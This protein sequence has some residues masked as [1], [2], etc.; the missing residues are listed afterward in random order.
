[1]N[2]IIGLSQ[3]A[4][5]RDTSPEVRDYLDKISS[6]SQSLLGILNDILDFSKLE[7]GRMSV[8]N[9]QFDLDQVLDNIRNLFEE[10][11]EAKQLEFS[12]D[13]AEGT[14]RDLVG[15][16][17]RIQQILSN[18]IGNA[19][20][21]TAQGRVVLNVSIRQ[22]DPAQVWMSFAVTDTGIGLSEEDKSKLFQPFSQVDG[23]I[24][25]KFGG[26]GLGLAISKNLLGLMGSQF[27]VESQPGKGSTFSFDVQLGIATTGKMR[28]V[29]VR[30]KHE[31]GQLARNLQN[32]ASSLKGARILVAEDNAINQQVVKEF[33]KLS[34]MEVEIARNGLEALTLLEQQE[35]DAVLMDVHMPVMGG[36]EATQKIRQNPKHAN[37]PV[38]AL[39]AGVTEEEREDTQAS[40]M[41]DFVAKPV[42]PEAL[43][44]T[45]TRWVN[46]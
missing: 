9:A 11:A 42:N 4:L 29:R 13:V 17:M 25:R 32:S 6:S 15:D 38:I 41:N 27:T 2:G 35:F 18:L 37:L 14:P 33:L 43:I 10:R 22:R 39:T 30:N 31:A 23:S 44:A 7:A 24:T 40:G 45:L 34:G 19:I 28:E 46:R 1:M 5:N 26:T 16:A 36:F 8:E 21:F 3:L 12:I 20:K